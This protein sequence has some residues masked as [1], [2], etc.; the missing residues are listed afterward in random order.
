VAIATRLCYASA[1]KFVALI[2]FAGLVACSAK[3]ADEPTSNVSPNGRPWA[4]GEELPSE[5]QDLGDAAVGE[6]TLLAGSYMSCGIPWKLWSDPNIGPTVK[7]GFGTNDEPLPGREGKNA[8]L[9]YSLT[10][11]TAA[12]GAEVV[13]ANCLL[14]HGGHIDGKL[15]IGLGNA[16][17]DFTSGLGGGPVGGVPSAVLDLLGLSAEE[18]SNFEKM[19]RTANVVGPE[20][21]M[22]T[23]GN[24][25]AE[26]LTAV[27]VAH[28][29]RDTLAWSDEPLQDVVIKDESGAPIADA[30]L[31]SDPPPWWRAHKK[32]ALFY[33]GM[34]RG[35]HR[36][37]MAL[38]SSVCVDSLEEAARVD[39]LFKDIQAYIASLRAPIYSRNVD[40]E[41]AAK[42]AKLFA[43]DCQGCHGSY[44]ADPLDDANDDYPNLILPLDVIG[45][46]PAV[47][48]AGVV[49]AP[50]LVEWYNGS[51]YGSVTPIVPD[52][53]FPG[54]V[55]PPLDGVWATAPYLHNG[56]V[57]TVELVLNS[58][59]R[60]MY[61]KRVDFDS[62]NLD[63]ESLGF[64]WV[65][66]DSPQAAQ[67][68][69][70]RALVYDTTYFS[71]SNAGHTFGDHLTAA[72]RRS[73]IEYLK[74]L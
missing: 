68:E 59:A 33:N 39:D 24:N 43:R 46:D 44:A 34:A 17:R 32:N 47:A 7:A 51:F 45:T 16:T 74:T 10:A 70:E 42:G 71:Q 49:H 15:V 52:D 57:P 41:L 3:D 12:D 56:S 22:R 69:A 18:K 53:P 11:F 54:Y 73:V 4:K 6:N 65:T 1:V 36:G 35:D 8:D 72:E 9:P 23:I 14:C 28:H 37:T 58:K 26:A 31:T 19:L 21:V 25:P 67:P 20:T 38:A 66:V 50:E 55:A 29:D 13:N 40:E 2:A 61:W 48:N 27:L 30:V 64:P 5:P 60:P 63:E 62:A